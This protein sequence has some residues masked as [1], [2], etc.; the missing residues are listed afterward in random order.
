MCT[1]CRHHAPGGSATLTTAAELEHLL[2]ARYTLGGRLKNAILP[3]LKQAKRLDPAPWTAVVTSA[4][5]VARCLVAAHCTGQLHGTG[6]PAVPLLPH[7]VPLAVAAGKLTPVAA[8]GAQSLASI[9]SPPRAAACLEGVWG[10][11]GVAGAAFRC[12]LD[13]AY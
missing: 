7:E 9:P 5:M 10:G 1:K 6:Q 3:P 11:D 13:A 12:L 8:A 4:G 2:K